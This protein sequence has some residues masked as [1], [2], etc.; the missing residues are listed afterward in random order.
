MGLSLQLLK[1]SLE[2]QAVA[3]A[4]GQLDDWIDSQMKLEKRPSHSEI[5]QKAQELV[6][7]NRPRIA[8]SIE[9]KSEQAK[10]L[11]AQALA[12]SEASEAK[13]AQAEKEAKDET[14][15]DYIKTKLP[16]STTGRK[17]SR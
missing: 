13:K 12:A 17:R 16:G 7:G 3:T 14:T 9:Y 15:Q 4:Q 11:A 1:S 10:D 6:E 2:Y 5:M 8:D